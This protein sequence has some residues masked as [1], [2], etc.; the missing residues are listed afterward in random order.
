MKNLTTILTY[1][2]YQLIVEPSLQYPIRL[3]LVV[4]FF[5]LMHKSPIC[6]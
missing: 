5:T 3:D 6:D 4:V 2:K 1:P